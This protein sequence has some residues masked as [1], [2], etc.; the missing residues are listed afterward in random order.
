LQ[1][2]IENKYIF[3]VF[4]SRQWRI[5][6][7]WLANYLTITNGCDDSSQSWEIQENFGE[8]TS[9]QPTII[10]LIGKSGLTC[11]PTDR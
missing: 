11:H 7:N 2:F 6:P 1:E 5:L 10:P 3:S 4:F 8:T 9:Q